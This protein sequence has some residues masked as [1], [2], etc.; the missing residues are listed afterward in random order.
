MEGGRHAEAKRD[1][2]AA[3]AITM[4]SDATRGGPVVVVPLGKKAFGFCPKEAAESLARSGGVGG[5]AKRHNPAA[6]CRIVGFLAL[7]CKAEVVTGK[8]VLHHATEKRFCVRRKRPLLVTHCICGARV[9]Q[10]GFDA[11]PHHKDIPRI[12]AFTPDAASQYKVN[13]LAVAACGLKARR[14][15]GEVFIR[16]SQSRSC[17]FANLLHTNIVFGAVPKCNC[18]CRHGRCI[19]YNSAK[20]KPSKLNRAAPCHT[21]PS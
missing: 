1:D 17:R 8:L 20:F 11:R 14:G 19:M 6:P 16:K 21:R 10:E 3:L 5:V 12:G 4:E 7:V 15:G 2:F 18:N 9:A 13:K